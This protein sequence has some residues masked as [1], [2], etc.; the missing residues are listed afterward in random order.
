M[1]ADG[2]LVGL[3]PG[4]CPGGEYKRG[5]NGVRLEGTNTAGWARPFRRH[6]SDPGAARDLG[7]VLQRHLER[8][9]CFDGRPLVV[10]CVGTP[11]CRGDDLGPLVGTRL[12][13][14]GGLPF[15]VY[16][17]VGDP[18]HA[19]NLAERLEE[20]AAIH[21]GAALLAVDACLGSSIY[22]G[23]VAVEPGPLRPG[24]G[25]DKRLPEFGDV[26]ITGTVGVYSHGLLTGLL[27]AWP[28]LVVKMA[29]VIADAVRY[30]V[31]GVGSEAVPA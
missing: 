3:T 19:A 5:G 23:C 20:I 15:T 2:I 22:V 25:V 10:V 31:L 11:A 12:K 13:A 18:M 9:G 14:G 16:G 24:S 30:A 26:C 29:D 17:T 6:H 4:V 21:S 7:V 27:A 8:L 1:T 28:P